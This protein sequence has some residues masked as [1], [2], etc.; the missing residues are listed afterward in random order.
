MSMLHDTFL[1]YT[2]EIEI[3]GTKDNSF[4]SFLFCEIVKER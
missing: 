1:L 2:C 3:Q 4:R